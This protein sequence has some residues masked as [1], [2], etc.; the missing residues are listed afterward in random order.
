[1]PQVRVLAVS[2]P[3][4]VEAIQ[5][6]SMCT[7]ETP[8]GQ[9][10]VHAGEWIVMREGRRYV[11]TNAKFEMD[12]EVNLEFADSFVVEEFNVVKKLISG[13]PEPDSGEVT[14]RLVDS[15]GDGNIDTAEV[16]G[17]DPEAD[18]VDRQR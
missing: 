13:D 11:Y 15:D 6:V 14:L 3:Y 2:R 18:I 7:V 17:N 10:T 16:V 4:H 8:S 5:C 1:M 9:E 12:F